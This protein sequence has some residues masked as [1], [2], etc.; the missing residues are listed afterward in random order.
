MLVSGWVYSIIFP[1]RVSLQTPSIHQ[2]PGHPPTGRS[3]QTCYPPQNLMVLCSVFSVTLFFF[4][5]NLVNQVVFPFEFHYFL[6]WFL[7]GQNDSHDFKKALVGFSSVGLGL[8][9]VSI[10]SSQVLL[11]FHSPLFFF[12]FQGER[13]S[14]SQEGFL[15][16][17][18]Y[19]L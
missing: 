18:I 13:T 6:Q 1:Y 2:P 12:K 4:E 14:H 3:S 11:P 8:K 7:L 17:T 16:T 10:F 15:I 5:S 9:C 19:T